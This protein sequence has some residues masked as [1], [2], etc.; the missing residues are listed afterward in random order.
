MSYG[1]TGLIFNVFATRFMK[2]VTVRFTGAFE[3]S[4]IITVKEGVSKKIKFKSKWLAHMYCSRINKG[5]YHRYSK[6]N[7]DCGFE[8]R[9]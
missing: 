9:K 5:Q 3:T 4:T 2:T 7:I 1:F 6:T 8:K